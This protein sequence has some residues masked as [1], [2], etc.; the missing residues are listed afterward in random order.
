MLSKL[1]CL[2]EGEI[3]R[4]LP[5][6]GLYFLLFAAFALADGVALTLFL[7]HVGSAFLPHAYAFVAATNLIVII[8]YVLVAERFRSIIIFHLIL[9]ANVTAFGCAWLALQH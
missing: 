8:L 5:F 2:Q 7:R 6:F 9:L 1:L 4:L 3:R